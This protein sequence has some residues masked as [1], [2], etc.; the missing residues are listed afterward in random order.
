M[1]HW[2]CRKYGYFNVPNLLSLFRIIIALPL[3]I[4]LLSTRL[5]SWALYLLIIAAMTDYLD[6]WLSRRYHL[7]SELGG[8]LDEISDVLLLDTTYIILAYQNIIP[9]WLSWLVIGYHLFLIIGYGALTLLLEKMKMHNQPIMGRMA[10]SFTYLYL[11]LT[12]LI[13]VY[14]KGVF[15]KL[16]FLSLF[17][18]LIAIAFSATRYTIFAKRKI[19]ARE[20]GLPEKVLDDDDEQLI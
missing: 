15:L 4:L 17:C 12:L 8:L 1:V 5:Y 3:M 6:G 13:E 18:L 10:A 14:P 9:R 20:K 2:L 7:I 16:H 19:E 11:L